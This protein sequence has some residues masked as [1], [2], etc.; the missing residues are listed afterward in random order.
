M[1]L[2][3]RLVVVA[4]VFM[5]FLFYFDSL[6]PVS[7]YSVLLPPGLVMS[8]CSQLCSLRSSIFLRAASAFP[9]LRPS[10]F[11]LRLCVMLSFPQSGLLLVLSLPP[12]CSVLPEIK[13]HFSLSSSLVSVAAFG[14]TF[15]SRHG[16]CV[17]RR[18]QT[19]HGTERE[20]CS[21]LQTA[22]L[23]HIISSMKLIWKLR[24]GHFLRDFLFFFIKCSHI[25]Q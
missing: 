20:G 5:C 9:G 4:S 15:S 22:L 18:K 11:V 1:S 7:V 17:S 12:V 13:A 24:G 6:R 23:S 16:V 25:I 10:S 19:G 21:N 3:L 2:V 14:S 8:Y